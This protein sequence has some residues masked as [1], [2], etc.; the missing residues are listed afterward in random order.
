MLGKDL[1]QDIDFGALYRRQARASSFQSRT[2]ADWDQRAEHRSRRE[3]G[4]DYAREF[5]AR[6]DLADA[7]T[8]LDIGCGTGNLALPLARRVRRVHAL[9]FSAE[10]LRLLR[11]NARAEGVRNVVAH[12]LAWAD[13]WAR[14]PR[15]DV[16]ICS[17]AMAVDDLRAALGKMNAQARRRC[18]LTLH[19]GGTFLSAD[20][21][22]VLRRSVVP[23]PN[24]IY[25]VNILYQ[26]GIRA[27]VDFL[28]TTGGLTYDSP[29]QFV[30]GIRWRVGA[31][32]AAEEKRLLAYFRR[33]P[34]DLDGAPRYRHDFTWAM[35]SWDK[36][37]R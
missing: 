32:T 33:L 20:V 31:L 29:E 11:A 21:Y 36:D 34:R 10:M 5:L 7:E 23:R 22:R 37:A 16:A 27:R 1:I 24:Y 18:Y 6:M 28:R 26:M 9:D 15:A 8:V 19:A 17:R 12:R 25:A 35:L 30:E 14:L 3:K 13:D 2:A 4:S